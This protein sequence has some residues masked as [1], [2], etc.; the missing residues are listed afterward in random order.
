MT[1]E[2]IRDAKAE[3]QDAILAVLEGLRQKT[4]TLPV[5]VDIRTDWLDANL[6]MAPRRV[7]SDVAIELEP[8]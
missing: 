8:I 5:G 4:G 3:A 2:E 6:S 7:V 1:L